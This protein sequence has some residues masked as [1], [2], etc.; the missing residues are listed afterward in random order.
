MKYSLSI[1]EHNIPAHLDIEKDIKLKKNGLHTFTIRING[2]NIVD[3]NVT[4][5]VD[6]KRK[7]LTLKSVAVAEYT[8]S[9]TGRVRGGGDP[10]RDDNI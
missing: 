5:F 6:V 9:Y 2:G 4:E 7:Y 8:I 3:Y 10:V 1:R